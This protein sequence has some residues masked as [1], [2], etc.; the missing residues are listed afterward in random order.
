M[1]FPKPGPKSKRKPVRELD[2]EYIKFIHGFACVVCGSYPVHAHH[3]KTRG[4]G[5]SD[6]TCLPLCYEHHMGRFGVHCLGRIH[7]QAKFRVDFE[8][9][10]EH[11]N[12]LYNDGAKGPHAHKVPSLRT[13]RGS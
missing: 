1:L 8:K 9:L 2:A 5:G 10:V 12:T 11:Y 6:L 3:T 7:F 13:L 4:A